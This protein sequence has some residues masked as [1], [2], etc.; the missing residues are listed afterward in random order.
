MAMTEGAMSCARNASNLVL[1]LC[2]GTGEGRQAG[3]T[4]A[5]GQRLRVCS[6]LMVLGRASG[7]T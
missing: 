5:Q 6:N 7:W 3:G 2:S 1:E 4:I